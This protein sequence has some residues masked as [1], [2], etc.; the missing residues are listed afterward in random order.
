LQINFPDHTKL[1]LTSDAGYCNF[2]CLSL[3]AAF[4]LQQKGSVPWKDIRDREML[5]GSLQQLLYGSADKTDAYKEITEANSLRA[6]LEF[7][8]SIIDGWL[9]GGG[10]GCLSHPQ[11]YVWEGHQL[12][13]NKKQDYVSVGRFGGDPS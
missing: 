2:V 1:I 5:Y 6:K 9:Q 11:A 10:L 13:D 4:R 8:V 3:E 7:I 12:E